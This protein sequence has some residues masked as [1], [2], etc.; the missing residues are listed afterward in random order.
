MEKGKL[1]QEL[2]KYQQVLQLNP[3]NV[4]VLSQLADIYE[5]TEQFDQAEYYQ[6]RI[7]QLQPDD[8]TVRTRLARLIL[9]SG[10]I[11]RAIATY[12]KALAL[13]QPPAEIYQE[14]ADVLGS[15]KQ[16]AKD[17]ATGKRASKLAWFSLKIDRSFK[18]IYRKL[19]K[20]STKL[21]LLQDGKIYL[22][23]WK[24]LNQKDL[25]SLEERSF[26]FPRKLNPSTVQ[27]YFAQTSQFKIIKLGSLSEKDKQLIETSG[28][29]LEYLMLNRSGRM[30]C[31]AQE[32]STRADSNCAELHPKVVTTA[33]WTKFQLSMVEEGCI[34]IICPSTGNVLTSDQSLFIG[35]SAMLPTFYRFVGNE[36]FYLIVFH[37]AFGYF[38]SCLYFPKTELIVVLNSFS[39]PHLDTYATHPKMKFFQAFKS[40]MV[41]NWEKITSYLLNQEKSTK[42]LLINQPH[43]HAY[44]WN[45]LTGIYK[46]YESS[47]LDKVDRFMVTSEPYGPIDEIFPEIPSEKICR[48]PYH[49]FLGELLENNYFAIKSGNCLIKEDLLNRIYQLSLKQCSSAFLSEVEEIR[50]SCFPLLS[51]S[52]RVGDK[53]NWISQTQGIANVIKNLA[54]NFPSLG[55]ILNGFSLM[56]GF[57]YKRGIEKTIKQE[58]DTVREIRSLLPSDIKVYDSIGCTIYES[59]VWAHSIDLYI[60]HYGSIQLNVGWHSNKPGVIHS[61]QLTHQVEPI[62]DTPAFYGRENATV[63]VYIPEACITDYGEFR[64]DVGNAYDCDWRVIYEEILKLAESIRVK[65]EV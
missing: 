64:A 20:L 61:S 18:R 42:V 48:V 52:I 40:Y 43:F 24:E 12:I 39:N 44:L 54:G 2:E 16:L 41:T 29:S 38:K 32:K 45:D 62:T 37:P 21:K 11:E 30:E 27:Q 31:H 60:A 58:T 9:K 63:P 51:I 28:L 50:K 3:D 13:P 6:R 35:G 19:N 47:I 26:S 23:I 57:S 14:L 4:S 55:V 10:N 46:L 34:S 59:I 65:E 1:A 36:V 49:K 15:N 56:H 5:D 22:D 33:E 53:R 25:K 8:A 17:I 7:V